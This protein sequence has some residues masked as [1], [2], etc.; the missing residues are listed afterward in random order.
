[1]KTVYI[2]VSLAGDPDYLTL[3]LF[4]NLASRN[5]ALALP[6]EYFKSAEKLGDNFVSLEVS[7]G[8]VVSTLESG[9]HFI[10]SRQCLL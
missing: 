4:G 9:H 10:N 2:N 6:I 7:G 8:K 3:K 5:T 1:M